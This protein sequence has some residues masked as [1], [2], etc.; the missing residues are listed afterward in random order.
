MN[1]QQVLGIVR[2][3]L[4]FAGGFLLAKGMVEPEQVAEAVA[5]LVTLIGLGWSVIG[6]A[7]KAE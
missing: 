3:A 4:T 2:H 6:K 1:Q 5:A 7:K